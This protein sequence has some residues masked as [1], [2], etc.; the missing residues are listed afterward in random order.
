LAAEAMSWKSSYQPI[1]LPLISRA[2]SVEKT[3]GRNIFPN[4]RNRGRKVFPSSKTLMPQDA[5]FVQSGRTDEGQSPGQELE[6][7]FGEH[8]TID[9]SAY[10]S[11][12]QR[13]LAFISGFN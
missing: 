12:H 8:G 2:F 6:A 9:Q 13:P 1:F 5:E 11:V 4:C 7:P 3:I 10:Y